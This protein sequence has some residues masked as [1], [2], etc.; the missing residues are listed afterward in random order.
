MTILLDFEDIG[1]KLTCSGCNGASQRLFCCSTCQGKTIYC[2]V[3][4]VYA[5]RK[6]PFHRVSVWD[7]R[8]GCFQ[9][10]SLAAL[11]LVIP[12]CRS[13]H[14]TTCLQPGSTQNLTVIHTNGIHNL[15]IQYCAC[16]I[17]QPL[18]LQIF[19]ARLFPASIQLPQTAFSFE[20]LEQFR[21]HHFEGKTSAY[22]FM[23]ALYRL[24]DDTGA[25]VVE[26]FFS[27]HW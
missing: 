19:A 13:S 10:T 18:D 21:F 22:I 14:N 4:I 8:S 7:F 27:R 11:G 26:V 15:T 17:S 23:N 6:M 25:T 12:L 24:T 2:H 3:C 20:V 1:S 16:A 5:H 9:Q